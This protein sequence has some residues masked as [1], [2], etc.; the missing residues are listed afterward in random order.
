MHFLSFSQTALLLKMWFYTEVPE[1]FDSLT[2]MPLVRGTDPRKKQVLAIWSLDQL[3]GAGSPDFVGSG[4]ASD[5]VKGGARQDAHLGLRGG[6]SWG[7][8][9]T[10]E[11]M[12]RR[13]GSA[14]MAARLRRR[15]QHGL[16]KTRH[17]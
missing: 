9:V 8:G 14:A 11:G 3:G 2:N 12:R 16:D 7:G 4:G 17:G 10:G 15:R 6:R 1:S 13:C 5:R